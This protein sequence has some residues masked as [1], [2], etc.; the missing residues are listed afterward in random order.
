MA[1]DLGGCSEPFYREN[2]VELLVSDRPCS[3]GMGL[4]IVAKARNPDLPARPRAGK[5]QATEDG[6][7]RDFHPRGARNAKAVGQQADNLGVSS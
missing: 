1:G 4:G 2:G 3:R 6:S 7:A 5:G